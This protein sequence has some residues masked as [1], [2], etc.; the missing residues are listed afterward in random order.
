MSLSE[1]LSSALSGLGAAQA[2]MRTVSNNIANVS[3]PGYAREKTTLQTDVAGGRITGVTVGEPNRIADQFLEATV[4][5]RAGEAGRAEVASTYLDRLQAMLGTTGSDSGL[6]TR[7]DAISS[8]AIKMTGSAGGAQTNAAFIGNVQDAIGS[9]QQLSRDVSGLRSDV[10]GE[11][12]ETVT[13]VNS[14]LSQIYDL[15][16]TVARAEGLGRSSAGAADQRNAAIEELGGLMGIVARQQAD[17]RMTV[18]TTSGVQLIDRR[19]RQL[20]Y[21]SNGAGAAQALYPPIEVRFAESDRTLGAATGERIDA[22]ASGKLGG[23]IALRDAELPAFSTRLDTLYS[24]LA[25]SLNAASNQGTAV[26]AP[27]SLQG[28]TTPL[29]T[30]DRLGFTGAATFAVTA[31]DGTLIAKTKVDFT[32]LG[33]G[34]TVADALTAINTGLGGAATA[35][36]T[37]GKLSITAAAS[38]NGVVVAQ[39]PTTPSSRAGTGFSQFFGLNDVVRSEGAMLTPTGFTA[40]DPHGLSVGQTTDFA[41]RDTSGRV[42][43]SY[44]LTITGST[45]SSFG[46]LVTELNASPLAAF[47]NF[48]LDSQGR[49]GFATTTAAAGN[50]LSVLSDTT[51]RGATG[52]SLGTITGLSGGTDA[53]KAGEVRRDIAADVTRLPLARLQ[54]V[55]VG[56]KALGVG[57]RTGATSFVDAFSTNIDLGR[58]SGVTTMSRYANSVLGDTGT[59]AARAADKMTETAARRDDAVARRDNFSGVSID[60]ELSQMVVLQNSY[61]A[62]ARVMSAATSMYDTLLQLA[63]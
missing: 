16:D 14:L 28:S 21:P 55:A 52:L 30:T 34:A 45:G 2:S 31:A 11:V 58:T 53:L 4:Y 36:F 7:L 29:A 22:A 50:T 46:A 56:Q 25:R 39:D 8:A 13:R 43:A 57:D 49:I 59:T 12:G 3:T 1:I 6:P 42:V 26:P 41:L 27:N 47:G 23:L 48:S 37:G 9:V 44:P 62:A 17:G 19:L 61:S 18:D 51:S 15:N 10:E 33:T 54:N 5:A 63:R 24:G 20:S 35:S 40:A 32:A 60:E 38:A